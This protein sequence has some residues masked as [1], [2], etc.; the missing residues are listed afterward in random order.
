MGSFAAALLAALRS[1]EARGRGPEVKAPAAPAMVDL[2]ASVSASLA[3]ADERP[4]W[5]RVLGVRVDCDEEQVRQAYRRRA[6]ETHP[7]RPGGSHE[8]FLA[9]RRAHEEAVAVLA[10]AA[11]PSA[12]E[13]GSGARY[14]TAKAPSAPASPRAY[15]AA[16]VCAPR[17]SRPVAIQA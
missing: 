2:H 10:T 5:A 12:A 9:V 11:A 3:A 8:A 4:R 13:V 7:D 16:P 17:A 6:F 14:E 15:R 1:E